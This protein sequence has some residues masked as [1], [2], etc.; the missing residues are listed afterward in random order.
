VIDFALVGSNR[1]RP[2]GRRAHETAWRQLERLR[3]MRRNW[4]SEKLRLRE[5]FATLLSYGLELGLADTPVGQARRW[6][7][8]FVYGRLNPIDESVDAG[9]DSNHARTVGPMYVKFGQ[10]ASWM[11]RL[12]PA[13]DR[14]QH[15]PIA[16]SNAPNV[17]RPQHVSSLALVRRRT[18]FRRRAR[19]QTA[20]S[21]RLT[22]C[23]G[24][25]VERCREQRAEG[26]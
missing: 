9:E 23:R 11:Q 10:I 14:V 13:P 20:A 26:R 8:P 6:F 5:A 7:T 18:R 22:R 3:S 15:L 19:T 4:I 24:T 12:M 2:D 17:I 1:P 25:L 16:G 21:P